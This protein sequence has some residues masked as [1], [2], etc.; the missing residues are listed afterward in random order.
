MELPTVYTHTIQTAALSHFTSFIAMDQGCHSTPFVFVKGLTRVQS[1]C[2]PSFLR[3]IPFTW[4][5]QDEGIE[6]LGVHCSFLNQTG[7]DCCFH[8]PLQ[9][10]GERLECFCFFLVREFGRI[11]V[12]LKE[13]HQLSLSFFPL[14]IFN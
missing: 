9:R 1:Y 13:S 14:F 6:G 12:N 8:H 2:S 7:G 10:W 11:F 4:C 5:K 3:F